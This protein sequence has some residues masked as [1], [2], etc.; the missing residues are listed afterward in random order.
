MHDDG[1]LCIT[2]FH[3]SWLEVAFGLAIVM[4]NLFQ[5]LIIRYMFFHVIIPL[6]VTE[7]DIFVLIDWLNQRYCFY[8]N[9][10]VNGMNDVPIMASKK[11][12]KLYSFVF[13]RKQQ[14][15]PPT[16]DFIETRAK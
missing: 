10:T 12:M 11:I 4:L 8:V 9:S 3:P 14:G 1:G 13:D 7:G 5:D 6:V 16:S 15:N 2:M